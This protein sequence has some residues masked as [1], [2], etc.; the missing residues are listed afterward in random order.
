M[1]HL[2]R[3]FFI[4]LLEGGAPFENP[5]CLGEVVGTNTH[6][7]REILSIYFD[8]CSQYSENWL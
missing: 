7:H 3:L 4:Q 1:A 8:Y 6:N 2:T 5:F